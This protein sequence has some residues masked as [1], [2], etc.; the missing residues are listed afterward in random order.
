MSYQISLTCPACHQTFTDKENIEAIIDFELCRYDDE[1]LSMAIHEG[2][3]DHMT[4]YASIMA[5]KQ[6]LIQ[7]P[8]YSY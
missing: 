1:L 5:M 3:T 6:K 8:S 7:D 2:F 4:A